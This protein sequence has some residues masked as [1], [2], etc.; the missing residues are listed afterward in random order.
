LRGRPRLLFLSHRL[1][2]P[3][4]WR[5]D[6][7]STS[8]ASWRRTST[9]RSASTGTTAPS[10]HPL[11]DRIAGLAPGLGQVFPIAQERSRP[12]FLWDHFRS[13]ASGHRT[14]SMYESAGSAAR[15]ELATGTFDLVH[16][17]SMD[18][19]RSPAGAPSPHGLYASQRRVGAARSPCHAREG[20]R[21]AYMHPGCPARARNQA[22]AQF[23]IN[24]RVRGRHR[25]VERARPVA[26]FTSIP[27]AWTPASSRPPNGRVPVA[28][29]WGNLLVSQSRRARV[30]RG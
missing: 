26:H 18:L 20:L 7:R 25:P 3:P 6:P 24:Y 21:S 8:C 13:I 17:D 28:C 29:S 23:D 2:F 12:R 22:A 9:C 4:Q 10:G 1:P 14:F 30:V 16:F 19:Q 5:V 27:N 15:Q 11:A